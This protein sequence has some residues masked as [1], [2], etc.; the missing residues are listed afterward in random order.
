MEKFHHCETDDGYW[1]CENFDPM[2]LKH[3]YS[4]TDGDG[5]GTT[6]NDGIE[7]NFCP[8]CGIKSEKEE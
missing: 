5:Y 1:T 6:Y 3:F 7:I 2:I 8:F 4:G